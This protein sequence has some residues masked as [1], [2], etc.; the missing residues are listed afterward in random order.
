MSNEFGDL[1][2]RLDTL[3]ESTESIRA[4][5]KK[6]NAKHDVR[7]RTNRRATFA[8]II[9]GLLGVL[10][11]GAG[12]DSAHNA[13]ASAH[14]ANAAVVKS[15]RIVKISRTASCNQSVKFQLNQRAAEKDQIRVVVDALTAQEVRS[16]A[17]TARID[18]FYDTYDK[19]VD[20]DHELRDCSRAGIAKYL[21]LKKGS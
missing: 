4:E 17:L 18:A 21:G 6:E 20:Q 5:I 7:I 16:P 12:V 10:V 8:A 2:D 13:S 15:N 19:K 9:V 11:G 3:L 14:K 1:Q